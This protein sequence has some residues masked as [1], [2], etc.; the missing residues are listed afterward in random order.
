M[1]SPP[2][3]LQVAFASALDTGDRPIRAG[4][5]APQFRPQLD[6]Y[7]TASRV[8]STVDGGPVIHGPA[9]PGA[10]KSR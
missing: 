3:G 8:G 4:S 1:I 9:I 2:N 10:G 5:K 6:C 7:I